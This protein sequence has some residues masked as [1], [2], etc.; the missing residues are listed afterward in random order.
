MSQFVLSLRF[1]EQSF[2]PSNTDNTVPEERGIGHRLRAMPVAAQLKTCEDTHAFSPPRRFPGYFDGR[3]GRSPS[4]AAQH[5]VN[6][7]LSL[8]SALASSS[9][10]TPKS[11]SSTVVVAVV[12]V[13]VVVVM[14][15]EA[16]GGVISSGHQ[17]QRRRQCTWCLQCQHP[18]FKVLSWSS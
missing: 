5:S 11:F 17:Q 9:I 10:V 4:C 1:S 14:A 16:S 2:D 7:E 18:Y 13:V 15:V 12:V 6:Y 8:G 3:Q